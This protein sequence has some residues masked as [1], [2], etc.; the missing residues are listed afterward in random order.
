[1]GMHV[2]LRLEIISSGFEEKGCRLST[3]SETTIII[4]IRIQNHR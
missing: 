1:M 2:L 4:R 3:A